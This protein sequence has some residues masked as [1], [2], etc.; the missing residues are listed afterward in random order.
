MD[1]YEATELAHKNGYIDKQ[2]DMTCKNESIEA[3][4][5]RLQEDYEILCKMYAKVNED[6]CIKTKARDM[7]VADLKT[8]CEYFGDC[9]VC[10]FYQNGKCS[11]DEYR[12]MCSKN[13]SKWEWRGI[14][15]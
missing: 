12:I 14:D 13:N 1:I 11:R 9:V 6:L 7:A 10:K 4:Y 2:C 5:K 15:E 8:V 3:K